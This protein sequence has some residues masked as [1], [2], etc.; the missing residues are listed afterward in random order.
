MSAHKSIIVLSE[1]S[2]GS[3]AFQ[4]LLS[5]FANIQH[6]LKTRHFENET[7]YWTKAASI[8]G[9]PQ[10]HMVDSEVPIGQKKARAD[11]IAL[12]EENLDGYTPPSDD[13]ELVIGGWRRLC[14]RYSPIFLEKS[15]HHL[16][17]WSALELIIECMDELPAV[18]FLLVG[19]IRNPMDTIYSQYR[20]WR[21]SPEKVER[22]WLVAYR[23]L[24]RLKEVAGERL[25]IVRY[26]EMISSLDHLKPVLDFCGCSADALDPTYLHRKS[27]SQWKSDALF[28]FA[29]SQEVIDLARSY[30]Y[31]PEQLRHERTLFWPVIREFSRARHKAL[32]PLRNIARFALKKT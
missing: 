10:L 12:L 30:G 14:E 26:E 21:S 16:C 3:S 5:G 20:R 28:G 18:D 4:N 1:K 23:N 19:L 9:M 24:L 7:L 8:L 17:Q 11:L 27:V 13:R 29:P 6:V 31:R 25:V 22:Q 32:V 15:P 2:S